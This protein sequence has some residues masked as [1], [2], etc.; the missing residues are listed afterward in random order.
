MTYE[1]DNKTNET[2]DKSTD[3]NTT[4]SHIYIFITPS[5]WSVVIASSRDY[6]TDET[7]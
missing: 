7:K 3:E 5:A 4:S 1:K 2:I 6:D